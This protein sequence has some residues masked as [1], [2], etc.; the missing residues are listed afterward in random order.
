MVKTILYFH[1]FASSSD[2]EKADILKGEVNI[3]EIDI[4]KSAEKALIKLAEII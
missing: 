4:Y 2:S 1:G 3:E